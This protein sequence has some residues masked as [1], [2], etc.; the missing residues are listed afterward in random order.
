VELDTPSHDAMG[1]SCCEQTLAIL[2]KPSIKYSINHNV[3]EHEKKVQQVRERQMEPQE[4][5]IPTPTNH[6][7]F[8]SARVYVC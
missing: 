1:T 7:T 5:S 4:G 3:R 2:G 8:A 6:D